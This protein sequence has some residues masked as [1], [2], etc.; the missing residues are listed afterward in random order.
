MKGAWND[1]KRA[2]TMT[3][4]GGY[5]ED[6]PNTTHLQLLIQTLEEMEGS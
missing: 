4:N 5:E 3:V 1:L 6:G 2:E